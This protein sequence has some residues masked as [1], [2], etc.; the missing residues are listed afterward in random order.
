MNNPSNL[1]S[2]QPAL[3]E[4]TNKSMKTY[5]YEDPPISDSADTS[6][7]ISA[8]SAAKPPAVPAILDKTL[9][10]VIG[11]LIVASMTIAAGALCRIVLF[12]FNLGYTLL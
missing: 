12:L 2:R 9:N 7:L 8:A 3:T 11:L 5:L 10:A 6:R 1:R 4:I